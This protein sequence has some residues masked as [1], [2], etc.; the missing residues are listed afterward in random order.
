MPDEEGFP[1]VFIQ[2]QATAQE[3]PVFQ[4]ASQ[5]LIE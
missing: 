4:I 5:P 3:L 1:K 2:T